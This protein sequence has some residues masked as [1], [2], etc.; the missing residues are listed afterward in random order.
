[1]NLDKEKQYCFYEDGHTGKCLGYSNFDDD[2][3]CDYCKSCERIN[4]EEE[5]IWQKKKRKQ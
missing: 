5:W 3:P 4:T 1:M 2:E